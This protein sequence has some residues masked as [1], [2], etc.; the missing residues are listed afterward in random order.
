MKN[1]IIFFLARKSN[2]D[3]QSINSQTKLNKKINNNYINSP[4]FVVILKI[5]ISNIEF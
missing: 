3:K 4:L 2:E 5:L 1:I